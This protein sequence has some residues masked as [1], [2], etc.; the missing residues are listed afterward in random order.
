MAKKCTIKLNATR[1]E[2]SISVDFKSFEKGNTDNLNEVYMSTEP[3][4]VEVVNSVNDYLF[5]ELSKTAT[6]ALKDLNNKE[7]EFYKLVYIP[8][9]KGEDTKE[10]WIKFTLQFMGKLFEAHIPNFYGEHGKLWAAYTF[11][12]GR[13]AYFKF[14]APEDVVQDYLGG[15]DFQTLNDLAMPYYY[16]EFANWSSKLAD[17]PSVKAWSSFTV[18][19]D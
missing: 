6:L 14:T 16:K 11:I 1:D 5:T 12:N 2:S 7:S 9:S 8:Y 10:N 15:F 3:V 17:H 13:Q 4:E 19:L 18:S